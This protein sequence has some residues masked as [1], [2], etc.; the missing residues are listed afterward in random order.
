M[1]ES[2]RSDGKRFAIR[3]ESEGGLILSSE[4]EADA[5]QSI[6]LLAAF[7]EE[8]KNPS[9]NS[10]LFS[11][12]LEEAHYAKAKEVYAWR[13]VIDSLKQADLSECHSSI[14]SSKG[15]SFPLIQSKPIMLRVAGEITNALLHSYN[16]RHMMSFSSV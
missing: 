3:C 5:W 8:R 12:K 1:P 11:W 4:L 9:A 14:K 13:G 10:M 7:L 16:N 6:D 2:D 15:K